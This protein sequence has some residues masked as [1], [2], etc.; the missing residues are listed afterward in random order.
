MTLDG[1]GLDC[2]RAL[3]TDPRSSESLV[4]IVRCAFVAYLARLSGQGRLTVGLRPSGCLRELDGL[5]GVFAGTVPWNVDVDVDAEPRSQLERWRQHLGRVEEHGTYILDLPSRYPELRG[6]ADAADAYHLPVGIEVDDLEAPVESDREF[7]LRVRFSPDGARCRWTFDPAVLPEANAR[8]MLAQFA[9][10]ARGCAS[11]PDRPVSRIPLLDDAERD[12]ILRAWNDT[13]TPWP[14]ELTIHDAIERQVLRSPDAIAVVSGAEELTYREL[15]SRSNR[16][17]RHLRALGVEPD[18][19]VGLCVERSVDMLVAIVGILKAGG[20]YVPLDPTYPSQ[21]MA[22][23]VE[24]SRVSVIVT[25]ESL[26]ERL[27]PHSA[28]LVRIDADRE[29]IIEASGDRLEPRARADNLAYVIYTSGSTGKPKGVMV[30]HRN[31]INFF[32]AMDACVEHEPGDTWLAVTI[33]SFDISV[34]ELLWTLARGFKVVVYPGHDPKPSRTAPRRALRPV[35]F[36]LFYFSANQAENPADKY[37]LLIEG[38]HF[39][40]AH[41]FAA[42]WTP[43][44]HFHEFGGLYPNPSLTGAAIA[45]ITKNVRIRAGSVVAPL[46]SPIRIAEEW[47]MVDNLSGGRVGIAF[48]SGWFPDDFVLKP[49]NFA[50]RKATMLR[51]VREVRDLWRGESV[52]FPG[53]LG[54]DVPVRVLPRPIQSELP[55]WV[56]T[57]GNPETY[58]MAARAGASVLTHLLGQSLKEVA[59]KV[60]LYRRVWRECGHPGRGHVTLMLHTFVGECLESVRATVRDPLINYLRTSADLIKTYSSSFPTFKRQG[61]EEIRFEDLS[62]EELDALLDHAFHRYF[63]TSGLFGT[64]RACI[65]MVERLETHDIDEIA[66]LID[67]GVDSETVLANLANLAELRQLVSRPRGSEVDASSIPELI[68]RHGVTHF[69]CTPSMAGMLLEADSGRRALRSLR[70]LL[71]GGEAIPVALAGELRDLVAGDV[72]NM[73][74]PTETTVWSS[75]FKVK[76]A[77]DGSVPIGRPVANTEIHI[78]DRQ[79]QPVPVGVPGELL[80]GGA[81]VVRGYWRRP[82]L[83]AERFIPHPYRPTPQARLYVTGDLARYRS[84]GIIEFLGRI[85]HQVK[86]RG[87]RIELGEIETALERTDGIAEAVVIPREDV[88]GEKRLVAYVK[89]EEGHVPAVGEL[90]SSLGEALPDFMVPSAFVLMEEF[91]LTPNG[92]VDRRA[93]PAPDADRPDLD[94]PYVAPRDE[95][96]R[97]IVDIWSHVLGIARVGVHDNFFDLGGDSILAVQIVSRSGQSGLKLSVRQLLEHETV[98]ELA[99]VCEF[100]R[101]V[102][103]EQGLITGTVRATP[104]QQ[105]LIE[106]DLPDLHY[107][108]QTMLL[109]VPGDLES[110]MLEQAVHALVA[111]HDAL[112]TRFRRAESGWAQS[113]IGLET[114]GTFRRFDLSRYSEDHRRDR[115]RII[116]DEAQASLNLENGPVFRGIHVSYGPQQPGRLLLVGHHLVVDGVSWRVLLDDLQAAYGQLRVGDSVRLPPKT[117]SFKE[118]ALKL[119]AHA[120][121]NPPSLGADYW[122]DVSD[123]DTPRLPVDHPGGMNTEASARAVVSSLSARETSELLHTVPRVYNTQINDVLLA[124]LLLAFCRSHGWRRFL[125]DLEGHG[126]EEILPDVDISR[127]VGWFTSL[128]PV[129]LELEA[130]DRDAVNPG[131]VLKGVKEQLRRVPEHGIGYGVLR[132]LSSDERLRERLAAVPRADIQFNYLGQ[133]NQVLAAES[134]FQPAPEPPGAFARVASPRQPRPYLLEILGM[135]AGDELRLWWIYSENLHERATVERLASDFMSSLRSILSHCSGRKEREFTPADFPLANLDQRKLDLLSKRL[136]GRASSRTRDREPGWSVGR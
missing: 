91:P 125:V 134:M 93:L 132:Y 16:L 62:A 71:V 131:I 112:R 94:K 59:Q 18:Q 82:E 118:W 120:R 11:T 88:P 85:D 54:Q 47:A 42:V 64:P 100:G 28:R 105:W 45:M 99:K 31:V 56:T 103:A 23:M 32:V 60:E 102:T 30:E 15:S 25:E 6:R 38:A 21:R 66:C 3:L 73:Y 87:H 117:T 133:F 57:A 96:E 48:A 49:E 61:G 79:R 115:L 69:Q 90:R 107:Y 126:R 52:S 5:N 8:L 77:I 55:V 121:T 92:K 1:E 113:I 127:T 101:A 111:H 110:A 122:F 104:I 128:F 78:V 43:E 70:Q 58:E 81:G 63:E 20:A 130:G 108:N 2:L 19:L 124:S 119:V 114:D 74:G 76:G 44:R 37:R 29:A 41:G 136:A 135:I 12:L 46:H 80:I 53:P 95:R 14:K 4:D 75:S 123:R 83:T 106:Q 33:L 40:D 109:T 68:E 36:S 116:V 98:A 129:L 27:P 72:I 39:A 17:A 26:A 65:E 67:F 34:L 7:D 97:M 24:D 51:Y 22:F 89:V 13:G 50:A 10:F 86:I 84:D 35:D 9:T